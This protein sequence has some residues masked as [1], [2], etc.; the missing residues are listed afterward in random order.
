MPECSVTVCPEQ[1]KWSAVVCLNQREPDDN[2]VR[3]TYCDG[4]LTMQKKTFSAGPFALTDIEPLPECT[5]AMTEETLRSCP[6]H[7]E[8][9]DV[10]LECFLIENQHTENCEK[11]MTEYQ[12]YAVEIE[13]KEAEIANLKDKNA[14][15]TE[16]IGAERKNVDDLVHLLHALANAAEAQESMVYVDTID[17]RLEELGLA[18]RKKHFEMVFTV[19]VQIRVEGDFTSKEAMQTAFEAGSI[20]WNVA[21]YE[22]TLDDNLQVIEIAEMK[23]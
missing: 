22:E 14:R 5:C 7:G 10:C 4:H 9:A 13:R 21:D 19:P 18:S 15:L 23:Q 11:R 2:P 16:E 8:D 3:V 17:E 12:T 1:A 6:V 20:D